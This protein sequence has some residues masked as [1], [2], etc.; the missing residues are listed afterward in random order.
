MFGPK[1]PKLSIPLRTELRIWIVKSVGFRSSY[2][3][4]SFVRKHFLK[5]GAVPLITLNISI[6]RK[7]KFY[8]CGE[9]AIPFQ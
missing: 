5:V 8:L 2:S 7:H 3:F 9:T 4:S 6:A 1:K